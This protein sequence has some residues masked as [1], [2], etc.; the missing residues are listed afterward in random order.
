MLT[1]IDV[2]GRSVQN[3]RVQMGFSIMHMA[4]AKFLKHFQKGP[5]RKN[6]AKARIAIQM[7]AREKKN[8]DDEKKNKRE[9]K[10]RR[11]TTEEKHALSA[12]EIQKRERERGL[13]GPGLGKSQA[14]AHPH[15]GTTVHARNLVLF[16]HV[17]RVHMYI[18]H[19]CA[20]L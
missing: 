15:L 10:N 13:I 1:I 14:Q 7:E 16:G 20:P 6:R 19:H 3:C 12:Y 2:I 4:S 18:G 8:E 11:K 5:N 9:K 17:F